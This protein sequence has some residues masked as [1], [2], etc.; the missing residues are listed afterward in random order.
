MVTAILGW[1]WTKISRVKF[2]NARHAP[3]NNFAVRMRIELI[4]TDRQSVMLAITL[5]NRC[6]GVLI[7]A[8]LHTTVSRVCIVGRTRTCN[9]FRQL[10]DGVSNQSECYYILSKNIFKKFPRCISR[11]KLVFRFPHLIFLCRLIFF[12][13]YFV[14]PVIP[15]SDH[16]F[17]KPFYY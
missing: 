2:C 15:S 11:G 14:Y 17:D 12:F 1:M 9:L 5:T 6:S 7:D 13:I 10:A 16:C 3:S 4:A 8:V